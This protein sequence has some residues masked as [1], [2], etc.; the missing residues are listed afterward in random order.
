M[1]NY[2]PAFIEGFKNLRASSFKDHAASEMHMRA[3]LLLKKEQSSDVREC[4]SIAIKSATLN[5]PCISADSQEKVWCCFRHN[6]GTLT[7]YENEATVWVRRE[8]DINLW[9]PLD[10][11]NHLS[12]NCTHCHQELPHFHLNKSFGNI[13]EQLV[14]NDVTM[15]SRLKNSAWKKHQQLG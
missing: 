5:G 7:F 14:K 11:K 4:A 1:C 6:K 10:H 15:S 2:N 3:M 9:R 13:E 12:G 8:D